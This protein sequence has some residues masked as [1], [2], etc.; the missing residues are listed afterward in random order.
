MLRWWLALRQTQSTIRSEHPDW[1][2]WTIYFLQI[3]R[4]HS[5]TLAKK[6]EREKM[7]LSSLPELSLQILDHAKLHG[8]V[9]I[10]DITTL[11]DANRNTIKKHFKALSKKGHLVLHGKG[12]AS[13]YALP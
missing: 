11:T 12:R 5:R 4:Q 13:W 8:R 7:I 3:L 10:A 6:V 9:T 2:P 1:Q